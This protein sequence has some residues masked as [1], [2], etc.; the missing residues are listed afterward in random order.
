MAAGFRSRPFD[1][2]LAVVAARALCAVPAGAVGGGG[3]VFDQRMRAGALVALLQGA[4]VAVVD[5]L[6]VGGTL[7]VGVDCVA[8][9]ASGE[10]R[11]CDNY[12]ETTRT[13]SHEAPVGDDEG[14]KGGLYMPFAVPSPGI[15]EKGAPS[16]RQSRTLAAPG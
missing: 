9:A 15:S 14:T 8:L 10:Q 6:A 3:A 7:R 16:A 13:E 2:R 1:A 11:D 5:A 4:G 12:P